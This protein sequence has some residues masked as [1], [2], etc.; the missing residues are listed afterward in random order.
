MEQLEQ[1]GEN[2]GCDALSAP[3]DRSVKAYLK[4]D[5]KRMEEGTKCGKTE[6]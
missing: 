2:R 3:A 4:G 5:E 1:V 6:G